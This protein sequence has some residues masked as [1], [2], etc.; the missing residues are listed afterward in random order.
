MRPYRYVP[1]DPSMLNEYSVQNLR[2]MKRN[3]PWPV[4]QATCLALCLAAD[5]RYPHDRTK[6]L[7][8]CALCRGTSSEPKQMH[9]FGAARSVNLKR[10]IPASFSHQIKCLRDQQSV[11]GYE[12][13]KTQLVVL[14]CDSASIFWIHKLLE[15]EYEELCTAAANVLKLNYRLPKMSCP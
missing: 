14:V 3:L 4:G 9:S 7:V 8:C 5:P 1:Y 13:D 2:Q 10:V 11:V 6:D 15:S 12:R